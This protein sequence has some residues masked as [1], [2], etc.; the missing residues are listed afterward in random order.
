MFNSLL[1]IISDAKLYDINLFDTQGVIALTIRFLFNFIITGIIVKFFYLPN[2][3][4]KEY[5]FPYMM[6]STAIFLLI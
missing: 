3:K 1:V 4:N 6:V 2:S 5:I